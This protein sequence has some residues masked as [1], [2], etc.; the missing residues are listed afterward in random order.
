MDKWLK[1]YITKYAQQS[2][3]WEDMRTSFESFVR[4]TYVS[5]DA[6][7]LLA[8]IDWNGWI[9]TP[10]LPPVTLDFKTPEY[11]AAIQLADD[12]IKL[13]GSLSPNNFKDYNGW[14]ENLK[15]IFVQRLLDKKSQITTKIAERIDGDLMLTIAPNPEIKYLWY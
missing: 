4:A 13:G 10:G 7:T 14:I 8:K 2:I 6:T 15:A 3:Y 11:N 12:Y 1:E 5:K 9:K